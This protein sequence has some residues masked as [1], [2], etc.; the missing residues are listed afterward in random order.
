M[1]IITYTHVLRGTI[2]R[3]RKKMQEEQQGNELENMRHR[4][5]YSSNEDGAL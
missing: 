2:R 1:S 4:Q 5:K 3:E